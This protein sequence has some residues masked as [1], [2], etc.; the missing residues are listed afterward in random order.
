MRR[1]AVVHADPPEAELPAVAT[2]PDT[3][4]DI[5]APSTRLAVRARDFCADPMT[6]LLGPGELLLGGRF[7]VAG[8]PTASASP[9]WGRRP[10]ATSP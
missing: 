8:R 9:S 7:P 10:P 6:T 1:E 4:L 5:V 2:R 3:T